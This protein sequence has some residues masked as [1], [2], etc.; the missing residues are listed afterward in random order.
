MNSKTYFNAIA[1]CGTS[2]RAINC[3][4]A[5]CGIKSE[6]YILKLQFAGECTVRHCL[7]RK[8]KNVLV[9]LAGIV[10]RRVKKKVLCVARIGQDTRLSGCLRWQ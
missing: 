5:L 4:N 7:K 2:N 6:A 10:I 1:K 8:E 3:V 9:S